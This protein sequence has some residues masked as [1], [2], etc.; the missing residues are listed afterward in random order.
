M[1]HNDALAGRTKFHEE[2]KSIGK[3]NPE[4]EASLGKLTEFLDL[5]IIANSDQSD[6]K[7]EL[8]GQDKIENDTIRT[9]II[10]VFNE[11]FPGQE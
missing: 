4:I 2:L 1:L 5:R 9:K 11:C 10:N 8:S 7:A 3:A 6:W